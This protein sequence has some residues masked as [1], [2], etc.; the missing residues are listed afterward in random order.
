MTAIEEKR[1]LPL[2]RFLGAL[3]IPGVGKRT[4]KLLAGFFHDNHSLLHFDK[5]REELQ[6]VKDIGP[7]TA[8]SII[9]YFD[10]H[11]HL[12]ERLLDRVIIAYPVKT[13]SSEFEKLAGKTFCVT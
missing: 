1:N 7:E 12:L 6:T 8:V 3:G 5:T 2:D 4:A 13:G 9:A 11:K 10:T